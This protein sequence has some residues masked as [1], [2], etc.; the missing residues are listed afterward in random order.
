M[1]IWLKK[2]KKKGVFLK[3][4]KLFQTLEE[5]RLDAKFCRTHYLKIG[6]RKMWAMFHIS[7]T[8]LLFSPL[9]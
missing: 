9:S 3:A 5:K 6:R 2:K 8:I 1:D 7:M 4:T